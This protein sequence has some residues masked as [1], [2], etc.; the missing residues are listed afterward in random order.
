M[1][2]IGDHVCPWWVAYTF[3]NALRRLVHAPTSLLG[4]YLA[5]GMSAVDVGCGMGHFSIGMARL[6]GGEGRVHAVDLQQKML[7]VT[8]R[9]A[10]KAGVCKRIVPHRASTDSLG[11]D[12]DVVVDFALLFWM[13][14]EVPDVRRLFAEVRHLLAPGGQLFLAEPAFHVSKTLYATIIER[15]VQEGFSLVESPKVRFS[16]AALLRPS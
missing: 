12:A 9:R 1:A 11:L 8:M 10:E 7:D 14:H 16:R 2:E 5:A 15:A 13:A 3:D 4:P 6:V